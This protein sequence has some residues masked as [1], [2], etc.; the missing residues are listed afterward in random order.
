MSVLKETML[1]K[2]SKTPID[3]DD[4]VESGNAEPLNETSDPVATLSFARSVI[5]H[6]QRALQSLA[7][8][9]DAE[10]LRAVELILSCKSG[11]V[12][13]TGM[14]KALAR[15]QEDLGDA[16]LDGDSIL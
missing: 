13:V 15:R 2:P 1:N 11:H 14:G 12:I 10:F 6:E 7:A 3:S 9:L 4:S 5:E 16:G 8:A